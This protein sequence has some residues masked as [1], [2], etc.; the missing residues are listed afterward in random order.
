MNAASVAAELQPWMELALEW[1]KFGQ[2]WANWWTTPHVAAAIAEP[3]GGAPNEQSDGQRMA[4]AMSTGSALSQIDPQKL[5]LLNASYLP[6]F[7]ALAVAAQWLQLG[8]VN[9]ASPQIPNVASPRPGDRRFAAAEWSELPPYSLLKQ[10]YLLTSEYLLD[11]VDLTPLPQRDRHRLRFLTRQVVDALAPT[12]FLATNPEAINRAV[13]SNGASLAH[14][15]AHGL[16]NFLADAK[17]GRIS[18][19]DESAFA[20]GRS[21][22]I[23][24]G[25]VVFR[26]DLI[27]LIQYAPSTAQVHRTPLLIVPPCIN[28]YYIL[29]LQPENSY[30]RWTVAQGYTVFLISWRNIPAA[31]GSLQWDDYIGQGVLRAI[32]VT[33]SISG[34]PVVNTLGFCVGGTILAVAL[35]VLAAHNDHSV[36][37]ATL[38]TTLLDYEDPG[39]IA[40][41]VS[42][43]TFA[44]REPLLMAG[45]RMP[46][47]EIARAFAS[48]RSNDLVWNYVVNNY[49]KGQTP[50]AFDLL[51]W[52]SDSANLPGPMYAYYLNNFYIEN[53][54]REPGALIAAGASID[55]SEIA[56]PSYIFAAREDHIVPWKSAY[57]S[58]ELLSGD[59]TFVL[60]ASGHIA[61]V[62]NPPEK[63]RRN[64]WVN[65]DLDVDPEQW[66]V[67]AQSR[68]GSWW[69][70]WA[71]WLAA[72]SGAMQ[73]APVAIG[74]A[75]YP[76]LDPAPGCYVRETVT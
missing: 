70:H 35:A 20:V 10:Y 76:A 48:L 54:L 63:K 31:L 15:L 36:A 32:E 34:S 11:L 13:K 50:P 62:V 57:R 14:G 58:I 23:T 17:K 4:N 49:L 74:S 51:F 28:K 6:R 19:T 38:L 37:S 27:E 72:Y 66:L 33:K 52:N 7:Q 39:D 41:Y 73:R 53:R 44:A 22:A 8:M 68:P 67:A 64:F 25:N 43:E 75:Q 16:A 1:Q 45:Q 60:G 42:R 59:R 21:L 12:N 40:C 69:P 5:A 71:A 9:G 65:A 46:G 2:Q 29:D 30:V 55:L 26:N 18:M 47:S 56:I 61:G 3:P 24:P